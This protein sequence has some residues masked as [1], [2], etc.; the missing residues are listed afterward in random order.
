MRVSVAKARWHRALLKA[1]ARCPHKRRRFEQE[2]RPGCEAGLRW[3]RSHAPV[4]RTGAVETA[5]PLLR[6]SRDVALAP[7][8]WGSALAAFC[9]G[10]RRI[11]GAHGAR[12]ATWTVSPNLTNEELAFCASLARDGLGFAAGESALAPALSPAWE[13][14]EESDVVI[15]FGREVT[16]AHSPLWQRLSCN[17][18]QP[19]VIA[20]AG[21]AAECPDAETARYAPRPGSGLRAAP[22]AGQHHHRRR[23][24]RCRFHPRTD[25]RFRGLRR[26]GRALYDRPRLRRDRTEGGARVGPRAN[27]RHR[28]ARE[29]LREARLVAANRAGLAQSRAAHRPV[30]ATGDGA[31]RRPRAGER[32]RHTSLCPDGL[33]RAVRSGGARRRTA[34]ALA[35]RIRRR[36]F[37]GGNRALVGARRATRVLRRP[38]RRLDAPRADGRPRPS[39]ERLAGEGR[40]AARPER[41]P[42]SAQAAP[43]AAG[44]R[45]HGLPALSTP[46]AILGVRRRLF[47]LVLAGDGFPD[48][49]KEHARRAHDFSAVADYAEID[50]YRSDGEVACGETAR[51]PFLFD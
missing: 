6:A 3:R 13:A 31:L 25:H 28:G 47:P 10:F 29:L 36:L 14:P 5:A 11:L 32:A 16:A 38:G 22:R 30:G 7:C 18:H 12:A 46:R 21:G 19:R 8:E 42:A 51:I 24:A 20:I 43:A 23:L 39:H 35:H 9:R 26:V 2:R 17:R 49:E 1:A 33:A 41:S 4:R 48:F 34:R 40:D 37:T 45:H 15:A 44:L 27:H 50:A